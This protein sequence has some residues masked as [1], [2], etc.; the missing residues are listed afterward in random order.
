[1]RV[2]LFLMMAVLM[3]STSSCE[4]VSENAVKL[5]VDFTW[6]NMKPCGWG[7][8]QITFSGVPDRTKFIRIHMFDHAYSYDH[9]KVEFPYKGNNTIQKDRFMD[10]QGPCPAWSPGEYEITIKAIDEND[11]I[12]GIGSKTRFFPEN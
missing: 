8:P 2:T 7:N 6:E 11:I 3:L 1:M 4:K 9:G 12:I 10:I 5:S